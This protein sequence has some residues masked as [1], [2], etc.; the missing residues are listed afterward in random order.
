MNDYENANIETIARGILVH[1]GCLLVCA[2]KSGERCYLP[3]GHIEFGETARQALRREIAE[4]M[5]LEATVGRFLAVT[6]NTFMQKGLPH[7]EINLV[8]ELAIPS[9]SPA[10]EPPA[11]EEWICFK[12]VSLDQLAKANLLP[13]HLITDIPRWLQAPGAHIEDYA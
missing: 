8:F 9:I 13:A 1:Q 2:P 10:Q 4:E 7:C 11:T 12:W 5:G 3:G 6:E